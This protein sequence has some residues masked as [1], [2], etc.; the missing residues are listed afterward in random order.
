MKFLP[1]Q[2]PL[3]GRD[4]PLQCLFEASASMSS[5]SG[6]LNPALHLSPCDM[7]TSRT[8]STPLCLHTSR[9]K[10]TTIC[11]IF[12]SLLPPPQVQAGWPEATCQGQ[13]P[14]LHLHSLK[15]LLLSPEP[16]PKCTG[17]SSYPSHTPAG[18]ALT[19]S[20]LG[21]ALTPSFPH[22]Q[23]QILLTRAIAIVD[24]RCKQ[25]QTSAPHLS[26]L[27]PPHWTI[28][29]SAARIFMCLDSVPPNPTELSPR[30]FPSPGHGRVVR[31]G[32][33]QLLACA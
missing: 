27:F 15:S 6:V 25:A 30:V 18:F 8:G 3:A 31:T 24:S 19:Q 5:A 28:S 4:H 23:A 11:L 2:S 10:L 13:Q 9:A 12:A 16:E 33:H 21:T 17:P 14:H 29:Q 26:P 20:N 1:L 7:H 32:L 22:C